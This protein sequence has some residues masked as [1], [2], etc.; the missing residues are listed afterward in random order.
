MDLYLRK[1]IIASMLENIEKSAEVTLATKLTES[2]TQLREALGQESEPFL[3]P[4]TEVLTNLLKHTGEHVQQKPGGGGGGTDQ[5]D[6][7][8]GP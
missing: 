3:A 7:P 5:N 2:A 4:V 8:Y 1:A 6:G